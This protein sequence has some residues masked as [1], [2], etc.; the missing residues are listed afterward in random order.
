MYFNINN[1]VHMKLVS[2][3]SPVEMMYGMCFNIVQDKE[4]QTKRRNKIP[5][6]TAFK[7]LQNL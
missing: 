7:E 3:N 4:G 5:K 1:V 2:I 6:K